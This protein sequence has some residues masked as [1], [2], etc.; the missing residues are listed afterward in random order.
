MLLFS[1]T[2]KN[3]KPAWLRIWIKRGSVSWDCL[4]K[5]VALRVSPSWWDNCLCST[6][7]LRLFPPK[8]EKVMPWTGRVKTRIFRKEKKWRTWAEGNGL[9]EVETK[10]SHQVFPDQPDKTGL[11]SFPYARCSWRTLGGARGKDLHFFRVFPHRHHHT[12]FDNFSYPKMKFHAPY[13]SQRGAR[14]WKSSMPWIV[15]LRSGQLG[16]EKR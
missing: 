8:T 14:F 2:A 9:L 3:Q 16:F 4:G 11:E 7:E 1:R 15:S 6:R 10:H 13:V 12:A 5:R